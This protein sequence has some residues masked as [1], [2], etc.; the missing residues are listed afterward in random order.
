MIQTYIKTIGETEV[1]HYLNHGTVDLVIC[2]ERTLSEKL[3]TTIHLWQEQCH[4]VVNHNHQL[5][6]INKPLSLTELSHFPAIFTEKGAAIRDKMEI[7]FHENQLNFNLGFEITTTDAIKTLVEYGL[8]W[9]VL[10][11]KLISKQLKI[12]NID[13][14]NVLINFDAYYLK[15]RAED[16]GINNFLKFFY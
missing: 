4:V 16:R 9:S 11:K 2:P 8:G 1:D 14:I 7:L 3:F 5:A 12:L 6:Q 10:P 15:K 13:A